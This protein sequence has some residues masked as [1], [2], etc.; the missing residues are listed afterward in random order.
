M[1]LELMN[2]QIVP[3]S[4]IR[5]IK[6]RKHTVVFE[7]VAGESG[8]T[9]VTEYHATEEEAEKRYACLRTEMHA[10]KILIPY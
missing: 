9:D 7:G 3:I 8:Y 6:L 4:D 5:S 10:R 1:Y 2:K